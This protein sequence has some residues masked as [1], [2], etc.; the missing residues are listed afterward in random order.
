VTT[1]KL[2]KAQQGLASRLDP[3]IETTAKPEPEWL[4]QARRDV[5]SDLTLQALFREAKA[6]GHS[7]EWLADMAASRL[8]GRWDGAAPDQ[9]KEA[10]LYLAD[11]YFQVGEGIHIISKETGRIVVTVTEDDIYQPAMVPREGGGMAKP[12]PRLDPNLEA[13]ITTWTFEES[14]EQRI[15]AK[16]V[17]RGHRAIEPTDPRL[18]PATRL[19]RAQIVKDFSE[20]TPEALLR[21]LGGSSGAFLQHFDL[22]ATLPG[23]DRHVLVHGEEPDLEGAIESKSVLRIGDQTTINIH[24]DRRAML[25]GVLPQ[26]WVR[27]MGRLLAEGAHKRGCDLSYDVSQIPT[28]RQMKVPTGLWVIPPEAVRAFVQPGWTILPVENTKVI[29]LT[30]PKVGTIVIPGRTA[31]ASH[32][33]FERWEAMADLD[34]K[35][36]V[37]WDAITCLNVTGLEYQAHVV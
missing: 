22:R 17:E 29:G 1:S 4:L 13:F 28:V 3:K 26:G 19:G 11:E 23:D 10:A 16:L 37:D 9:A 27:E 6:E 32:E 33:L 30:K 14:R 24:H 36:W 7:A 25:R 2:T 31:A 20:T 21:G 35:M 8:M 34:F 5:N 12:L 15:I 18:H